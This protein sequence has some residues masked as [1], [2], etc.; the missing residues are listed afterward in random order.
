MGTL[1]GMIRRWTPSVLRSAREMLSENTMT[2]MRH[3]IVVV[4]ETVIEEAARKA[5][6]PDVRLTSLT[7]TE[8]GF[9]CSGRVGSVLP[10]VIDVQ[11]TDQNFV[12]DPAPGIIEF[13][14]QGLSLAADGNLVQRVV[15]GIVLGIVGALVGSSLDRLPIGTIAGL[16]F[17]DDMVTC[18]LADVPVIQAALRIGNT[19]LAVNDLIRIEEVRFEPG[20][21]RI[22]ARAGAVGRA[23]LDALSGGDEKES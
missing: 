9:R 3:G 5:L 12:P 17:A 14:V 23:L 13:R 11:G 20:H 10:T 19:G 15:G 7:L 8:A 2:L 18:R 16:T 22:R 6:E 1:L 4:P 21:V